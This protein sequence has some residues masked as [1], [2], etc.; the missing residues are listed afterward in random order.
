[1]TFNS[2]F[3]NGLN[4]DLSLLVKRTRMEWETTSSLDVVNVINRFA[5]T[6]DE[7]P[8]SKTAKTFNFQH[9]QIKAPRWNQKTPS[10]CH[11]SKEPGH[12]KR[13]RHKFR[14]SGVVS[15]VIGLLTSLPKVLLTLVVGLRGIMGLFSNSPSYQLGEPF[16]PISNESLSYDET[17]LCCTKEW[18]SWPNSMGRMGR[19]GL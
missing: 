19:D 10:F 18:Q 11:F 14:A 6:L 1:M 15:L 4:R 7:P 5:R 12:W 13:E 8:W 9:W 16:L 2:L 17:S 3:V